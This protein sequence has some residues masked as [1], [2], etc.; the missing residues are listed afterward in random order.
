MK[1]FEA[2][3]VAEQDNGTAHTE[4]KRSE[5]PWEDKRVI[6]HRKNIPDDS[7]KVCV[8]TFV[9]LGSVPRIV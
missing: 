6:S 3:E 5:L 1:S 8:R 9:C 2:E 4:R 7:L